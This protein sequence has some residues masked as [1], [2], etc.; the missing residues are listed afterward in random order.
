MILYLRH[1][2]TNL[3]L[4]LYEKTPFFFGAPLERLQN[5][6]SRKE[7]VAIRGIDSTVKPGENFS[8]M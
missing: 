4:T 5:P 3:K 8:G 2:Y 7:I 1:L 6:C